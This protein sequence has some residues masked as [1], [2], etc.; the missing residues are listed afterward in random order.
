MVSVL[1]G[2]CTEGGGRGGGTLGCLKE[3]SVT[4]LRTSVT[5]TAS[6]ERNE[7]ME[8]I[9]CFLEKGPQCCLSLLFFVERAIF[10]VR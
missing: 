6:G 10:Q 4:A 8:L 7:R 2:E 5:I 3:L 1:C 9:G